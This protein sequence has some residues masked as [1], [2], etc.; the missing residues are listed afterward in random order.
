MLQQFSEQSS[1]IPRMKIAVTTGQTKAPHGTVL[2]PVVLGDE[3]KDRAFFL[4]QCEGQSDAAENLRE[5]FTAVLKHAVLEG[6]GSGYERLES[7]LKELN[8]LLKGFMLS[9]AVS[10]VHAIVGLIEIE[11]PTLHLSNVGRAEAYI[12]RDGTATQVTEFA[13]RGKAPIAFMQI[14]SGPIR[15]RDHFIVSSQRLLRTITPA[16][17]VKMTQHDSETVIQSIVSALTAEKEAACVAHII[18][19]GEANDGDTQKETRRALGEGLRTRRK[20]SGTSLLSMAS[21]AIGKVEWSSLFRKVKMMKGTEKKMKSFVERCGE[22]ARIF[23]RDLYD[24]ERKRRAHLLLLAGSAA[25]FLI[26]WMVVQLSVVSQK[27]QT[28]GELGE[29]MKQINSD[30]STAENRQLAGDT[31]NANM[32][33]VRAEERAKQVMT[34]ESGLFRSEALELLERIKSKKEE[35][36]RVIR[37][38]PPRVMA[39]LGAKKPDI[40][41]QGFIGLPNGEFLVY[42]RQ[43]LYRI[44]LNTVEDGEKIGSEEL[45]LKGAWFPRFQ[46]KVFM[47]TGNSVIEI[48]NGQA[49]TMKT[50]D[51]AGWVTGSDITTYLRYLYVL[52]PERKQIYKYE[53]LASKYGPPAEYNINGDLSGAIDMAIVGPVYVL[54]DVS[55]PE[56][57]GERDVQ[58]LL[59]GEKQVFNIRNLPPGALQG[60]TKIFRASANGNFYFLDPEQ[61]RI[62]VTTGDGDLGDSLYLKQYILDSDEVGPLKDLYVD[63]DDSRLYVLDEK[64]LYAIDLQSK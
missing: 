64:K 1:L 54:R 55:T 28:K 57:P 9:E 30:L 3:K 20:A 2:V 8:G 29:L 14:L 63:P 13:P 22:S 24:P 42:D 17:L 6:E 37:V 47:T 4:M 61:R 49:T 46:S 16:Q 11:E 43:N 41:A 44:S 33:L 18:V 52:S 60:V 5:E 48:I 25:L 50:E 15:K 40:V 23:L 27:S 12:I 19:T 56:K 35:M 53:R 59:R 10:D 39:N 62:V 51:P 26:L 34:S 58:K 7:A 36:N 31:E 38:V 32:I 45:I 21:S